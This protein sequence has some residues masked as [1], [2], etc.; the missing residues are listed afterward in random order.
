MHHIVRSTLALSVV[1]ASGL[2]GVGCHATTATMASTG[3]PLRVDVRTNEEKFSRFGMVMEPGQYQWLDGL[4]QGETKI[5]DELDFY[6]VAGDKEKE[7]SIISWRKQAKF[8]SMV[9]WG[10]F[11]GS[12]A[13]LGGGL[14]LMAA[15][16]GFE[17]PESYIGSESG[18]IAV[19]LI[20]A[21]G[22]L[23]GA[24][25]LTYM[26]VG[27]KQQIIVEYPPEG[28]WTYEL[29]YSKEAATMTATQYNA[30]LAAAAPAEPA[31]AQ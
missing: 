23:L 24:A 16:G 29:V 6:H 8:A 11:G 31:P 22:I 7:E 3:E 14:G 13:V 26:C 1:V 17:N 2:S 5:A 21:G 9:A 20:T 25:P 4:Y 28:S 19:G 15:Q 12:V 27:P 18:Q 30:T 10:A